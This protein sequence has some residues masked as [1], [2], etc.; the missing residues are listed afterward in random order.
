MVAAEHSD[1]KIKVLTPEDLEA[2]VRLLAEEE[3]TAPPKRAGTYANLISSFFD[4]LL[5]AVFYSGFCTG[6]IV[7]W[8]QFW[9][10]LKLLAIA[11][12]AFVLLT[13]KAVAIGQDKDLLR[14]SP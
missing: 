8:F 6:I 10:G 13:V 7:V 11:G 2:A 9:P 12:V 14:N 3:R 1:S 4:N 5:T